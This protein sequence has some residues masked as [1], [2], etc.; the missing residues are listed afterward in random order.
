MAA[1]LALVL[2]DLH[3]PTR[4]RDLPEQFKNLL[5]PG[6][7]HHVL[8]TGNIGSK[9]I[10]EYL[11]RTAPNYHQVRGDF[12]KDPNLPEKK[13][14]QIGN[15]K[16][17]IIHGH[18]VLFVV[19]WGDTESLSAI[20]RQLD[21]DILISG[22]THQFSVAT[23]DGKCLIN[24]GSATGAYSSIASDVQP[25]FVLLAIQGNSVV[26]YV[27]KIKKNGELDVGRSTFDK[28]KK[29]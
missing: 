10:R 19:P 21:V 8:A 2:G 25:S 18:Q 13:V 9:Q 17:G 24:P 6:K 7:I 22:H 27:Y 23:V 11:T 12:D 3:V 15:F 28:E 5:V 1:Q 26:I 16:I 4:S 29:K 14:V 20:Q